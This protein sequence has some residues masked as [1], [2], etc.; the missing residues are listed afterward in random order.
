MPE[1]GLVMTENLRR[2]GKEPRDPGVSQPWPKH[3]DPE[4]P[5]C[6]GHIRD[7]GLLGVKKAGHV[8]NQNHTQSL[9]TQKDSGM[10]KI[11]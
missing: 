9:E 7:S 4:N 8:R 11:F 2:H 6:P 3:W 1:I 10:P 5:E